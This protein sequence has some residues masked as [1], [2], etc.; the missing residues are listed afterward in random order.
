[1]SQPQDD[2]RPAAKLD[3]ADRPDEFQTTHWSLVLHAG[4]RSTV[5]SQE[6]MAQLCQSYWWPL[7]TYARR[8]VGDAHQAQDLTQAFFAKLLEKDYLRDASPLR[9][10][11]RAFLLTALKRFMANEWDKATAQKRGGGNPTLPLDFGEGERQ[12][13]REPVDSMTADQI[14]LKNWARTLLD[15]VLEQLRLEFASDG[16]AEQFVELQ[17]FITPLE[18][19][20][21]IADIAE[22]LGMAESALRVAAHRLRKRYRKLLREEI[23]QTVTGPDEIED[24]IRSLFAAFGD[25]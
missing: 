9:G 25:P 1:M 19:S 3:D 12:Y 7:Y 21:K 23:A 2:G 13:V 14:F 20:I 4:C 16:K 11:F 8:R 10:R 15:R 5:Q 22:R 17:A 6:A 24:E 18:D